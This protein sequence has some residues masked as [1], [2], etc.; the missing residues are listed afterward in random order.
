MKKKENMRSCTDTAVEIG[1]KSFENAK[2]SLVNF[3]N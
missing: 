2:Q 3:V 1:V